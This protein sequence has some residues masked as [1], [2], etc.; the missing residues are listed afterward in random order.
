MAR[1]QRSHSIEFERQ[2]VQEYIAGETLY[3]LAKRHA[4]GLRSMKPAAWTRMPRLLTSCMNTK[5]KS[6]RWSAWLAA[7]L[8]KSNF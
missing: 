5:P 1:Q 3:G 6:W 2:V 7:R 4:F 8:W